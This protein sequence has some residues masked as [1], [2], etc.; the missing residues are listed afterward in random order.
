V[1]DRSNTS[2]RIR[3]ASITDAEQILS[4]L[5]AAF[6]PYRHE[7]TPAGFA[8]TVLSS[9]TIAARLQLMTLFVAED[10]VGTIV[11]TVGSSV[12]SAEEGHIRGMAVLPDWHGRGVAEELLRAAEEE[13]RQQGCKRISLDTTAPLKRA[14]KFYERNGYRASGKVNDFFGMQLFEYLKE[15]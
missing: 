11:G 3:R 4:C 6:E 13:L 10:K 7:Y 8:D 2:F 9:Q 14:I 5:Q 15:L 12:V 1:L